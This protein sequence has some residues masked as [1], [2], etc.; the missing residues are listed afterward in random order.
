M[1]QDVLKVQIKKDDTLFQ[2]EEHN[3]IMHERGKGIHMY[4][5][6]NYEKKFFN[7]TWIC[8][9][10]ATASNI[11]KN[12][13]LTDWWDK[14]TNENIG[15][16]LSSNIIG[17]TSA[18]HANRIE[19]SK[20]EKL[21]LNVEDFIKSLAHKNQGLIDN[22]AVGQDFIFCAFD[23]SNVKRYF[24]RP[25]ALSGAN[26]AEFTEQFMRI[27]REKIDRAFGISNQGQ[28][29]LFEKYDTYEN[30]KNLAALVYELYENTIQHG[31][32]DEKGSLIEGVRTLSIKRHIIN[33]PEELTHQ[34]ENF[35]ELSHYF[36]DIAA[37]RMNKHLWFYE[38]SILDNGIGIVKRFLASRPEYRDD[39]SFTKLSDFDKLNYI[40]TESLSSKL[41][42]GAG[43]GIKNALKNLIRLDGF[44]SLRTNDI[45]AYFNGR[46]K[47]AKITPS[48]IKV[49]T[50][51]ELENMRGT[52]YS[53]IIPVSHS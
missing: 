53:I 40:I 21:E 3:R 22:S 15:L 4:L 29:S 7:T 24:P 49:N 20:H 8:S 35:P 1:D 5:S 26:V 30:E 16:R 27:K 32:K 37:E 42:S 9:L 12:F 10:I 45:W 2:L 36:Q 41:L 46:S 52:S 31:N 23:S 28:T 44:V 50:K 34:S 17:I 11:D 39:A 18:C 43:R 33:K 25:G 6:R 13:T 47:T 19:N 48:F 51:E 14:S 38:I